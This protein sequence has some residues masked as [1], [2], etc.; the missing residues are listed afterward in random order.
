MSIG[1]RQIM[2][3]HAMSIRPNSSY[4]GGVQEVIYEMTDK[5]VNITSDTVCAVF[6][7]LQVRGLIVRTELANPVEKSRGQRGAPRKFYKLTKDGEQAL[8]DVES[9]IAMYR[10]RGWK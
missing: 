10:E 8:K 4:S 2:I 9:V 6:K 3:L 1:I 5:K 7:T